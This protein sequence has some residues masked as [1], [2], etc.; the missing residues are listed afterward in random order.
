MD[1]RVTYR[2]NIDGPHEPYHR[3]VKFRTVVLTHHFGCTYKLA[4]AAF[5][6]VEEFCTRIAEASLQPREE[7]ETEKDAQATSAPELPAANASSEGV[8]Q[9]DV[10]AVADDT[11][12]RPEA[13]PTTT[14]TTEMSANSDKSNDVP[15]AADGIKDGIE[16]GPTVTEVPLKDDKVD[17]VPAAADSSK[18]ETDSEAQ[19]KE[20]KEVSQ[21]LESGG[22]SES[23]A[24]AQPQNGDLPTCGNCNGSLSFPFWYCIFCS[25]QSVRFPIDR[26]GQCALQFR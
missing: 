25:G 17:D 6:R 24:Q 10:P 15:T 7:K 26:S 20:G 11:K 4:C 16:A 23:L 19:D 14:T 1:A 8:K 5:E 2:Q 9:D 22:A 13:E 21:Q 3:L 12:D 18:N